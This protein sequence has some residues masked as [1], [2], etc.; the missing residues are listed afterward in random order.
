VRAREAGFTLVELVMVLVIIAILL[1]VALGFHMQA[2][3]R[4]SDATAKANLRVAVPAFEAYQADNG[5]YAGMTLAS[6][7]AT[8]SP[9]VQ[10]IEVLSAVADDYCVRSVV[11]S[12]AWYKQGPAGPHHVDR[13][14]V[15]AARRRTRLSPTR[16]VTPS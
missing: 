14:L 7:Q 11:G 1:A 8:Y 12:S 3:T 6:L 2:R 5:T 4:A 9:G 16:R 13:V 10:G 15:A